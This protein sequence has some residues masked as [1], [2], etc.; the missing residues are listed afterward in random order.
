MGNQCQATS[1]R[2][3]KRCGRE[4]APGATTCYMHGSATAASRAAAE[5]RHARALLNE[6]AAQAVELWGGRRD[7]SMDEALL[8]LFQRKAAEVE[9][10]RYR[11]SQIPEADLLFGVTKVKVGGDDRGTTSEA[12]PV[13]P[14]QMLR[15]AERELLAMIVAAKRAGIEEARLR[16]AQGQ[17]QVMLQV[18]RAIFSDPRRATGDAAEWD[19]V[20]LEALAPVVRPELVW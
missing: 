5:R 16:I 8:E 1:K 10:W 18:L 17:A 12:G 3:G 2:T 15:D 13:G 20:V 19:Q 4:A 7:I 9:Y 14:M 11:V 6:E